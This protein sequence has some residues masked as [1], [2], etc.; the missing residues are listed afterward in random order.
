MT[1]QKSKVVIFVLVLAIAIITGVVVW[2]LEE[3]KEGS[4]E[5]ES[6]PVAMQKPQVEDIAPEPTPSTIP[7]QQDKTKKKETTKVKKSQP[8][9]PMRISP[10]SRKKLLKNLQRR[11]AESK[12]LAAKNSQNPEKGIKDQKEYRNYVLGQIREIIPLVQECYRNALEQSPDLEGQI[13]VRFAVIAD[14]EYGGLIQDS[15]IMEDT[16]GDESMNEC[17]RE[18][19]YGLHLRTPESI[20]MAVVTYPFKFKKDSVKKTER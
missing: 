6:L 4:N 8:T 9:Y 7:E 12:M 16:V 17:V 11:L 2:L 18:T 19:M 10:E 15:E 5:I 20:G 14:P 13:A 3:K 1:K